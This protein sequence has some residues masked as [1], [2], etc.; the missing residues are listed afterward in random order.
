MKFSFGLQFGV[1]PANVWFTKQSQSET[2]VLVA[3]FVEQSLAERTV[4]ALQT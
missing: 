3:C 1:P 2:A 4:Y